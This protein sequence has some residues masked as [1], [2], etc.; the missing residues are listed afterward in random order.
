MPRDLPWQR[1][2]AVAISGLIWS[3]RHE[4]SFRVHLPI[5][6]AVISIAAWLN[7]D[8]WRWT[9]LVMAIGMVVS[10]ELFNTSIEQLVKV[11]HPEHDQRI[12][13]ALNAA[14]GAVLI[15]SLAAVVVGLIVLGSPLWDVIAAKS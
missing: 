11:I 8:P 2:F 1:K 4:T 6:L 5:A 10:A 7:V 12:G 13:Q 9:V 14:A 15:V 3:F